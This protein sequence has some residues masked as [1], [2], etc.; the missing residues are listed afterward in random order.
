MF[1]KFNYLLLVVSIFVLLIPFSFFYFDN[2]DNPINNETAEKKAESE[3]IKQDALITIEMNL[4]PLIN[5]LKK[6]INF[7]NRFNDFEKLKSKYPEIVDISIKKN[8][9]FDKVLFKRDYKIEGKSDYILLTLPVKSLD[10]KATYYQMKIKSDFYS[11]IE[12]KQQLRMFTV[13]HLQSN[14]WSTNP[15]KYSPRKKLSRN[16]TD[17][18]PD[19]HPKQDEK[20]ISHY[21][22]NEILIK[23]KNDIDQNY[24]KQLILKYNLKVK[25]QN[26]DTVIVNCSEKSTKELIKLL[27]KNELSNPSSKVEY[28]EPHFLYLT[29]DVSKTGVTS[30]FIPNDILYQDYQWNLPIINTNQAW[31]LTRG[32]QN[33]TIA[34]IDT[35]VDLDH[36]EFEGKLVDGINLLELSLSPM[37]DDGHGTHVAGII[38]ANTNNKEGIAGISWYNKIM[39]V[40]V[41]D[42]SGAGTLFDVAEGIIWATDHGAKVINMSLGNYAESKYLHDAVKYAYAK[43]VVLIAATGNDNT[44]ELGYPAAYKEVIAV[45]A[46]DPYQ[47]RAG[48]SN[49]GTYV[50]VVAPGVNIPS[51]YPDRQ[52]AA[53]SGTSMAAPHVSGLAGLIRSLNPKLSNEDVYNM[54]KNSVTDLGV[55]G[56]DIYYGYG[57]INVERALERA[58]QKPLF[59]SVLLN[60]LQKLFTRQ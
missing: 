35:G 10:G 58:N 54:I 11:Q 43:D 40:K 8:V 44:D 34:V 13:T 12:K 31:R 51:T 6:E 56:K 25:K 5:E 32:R 18:L 49:F 48:F 53:L 26:D 7:S 14:K 38:S 1:N 37:D 45:S 28:V 16:L 57:E 4:R 27:E 42:Q 15:T 55:Q 9:S 3:Y 20:G 22:N 60:W 50:D 23:F 24:L 46:T 29:N 2:G 41:L 19:I 30:S 33:V 59:R 17:S 39:P 47:E 52:Y 21:I 36:P